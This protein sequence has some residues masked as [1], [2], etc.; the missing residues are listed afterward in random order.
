V[1]AGLAR[2]AA[3]NPRF[4]AFATVDAEGA[5]TRA[6]EVDAACATAVGS[7]AA[8]HDR[9]DQRQHRPTGLLRRRD[10]AYSLAASRHPTRR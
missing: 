4:R 10:R 2:I 6:A 7:P 9:G 5:R 3:L 8:R 1:D